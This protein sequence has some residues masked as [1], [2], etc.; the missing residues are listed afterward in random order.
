M[1]ELRITCVTKPDRFSTHERIASVGV[2]NAPGRLSVADVIR[3]IR[4]QSYAFYTLVYGQK[5]YVAVVDVPGRA[6]Y[7]RTHADG[8]W[9]DNLLA[10]PECVG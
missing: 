1:P 7:I 6:S 10:L 2:E 3:F 4:S 9:N 8:T 5:A